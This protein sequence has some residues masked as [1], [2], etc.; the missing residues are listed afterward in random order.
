MQKR[1]GSTGKKFGKIAEVNSLI[2]SLLVEAR[3]ALL[4]DVLENYKVMHTL[5]SCTAAA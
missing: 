1:K 2:D 5:C 4:K 3:D